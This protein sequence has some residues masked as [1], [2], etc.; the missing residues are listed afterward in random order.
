MTTPQIGATLIEALLFI[1]LVG[2]AGAAIVG[3]FGQAGRDAG[4]LGTHF[5]AHRIAQAFLQEVLARPARCAAAGEGWG[6]EAGE[7][8]AA[9]DHV[10]DYHGYDVQGVRFPSS[11]AVDLDGDGVNDL[12]DYR[13]R[14]TVTQPGLGGIPATDTLRVSVRVDHAAGETVQAEAWRF[15]YLG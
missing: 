11:E 10:N 15:C 2:I 8:R 5:E 1:V 3:V 9:Y 7:T 12:R 6:P 14:I 4:A 13:V